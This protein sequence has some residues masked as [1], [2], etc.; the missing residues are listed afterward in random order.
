M[1]GNFG[2]GLLIGT[3]SASRALETAR[4][5]RDSQ[6]KE[7]EYQ[8]KKEYE[9]ALKETGTPAGLE[10]REGFKIT[11]QDGKAFHVPTAEA[12]DAYVSS[13][14]T[15]SDKVAPYQEVNVGSK[16]LGQHTGLEGQA[17]AGEQR[18][19]YNKGADARM[20]SV[21]AQY[22]KPLEAAAYQSLAAGKLKLKDL[23]RKDR[24]AD[25]KTNVAETYNTPEKRNARFSELY[26]SNTGAFGLGEHKDQTATFKN[27]PDGSTEASFFKAD[28]TSA[29]SK[30][31]SAAQVQKMSMK[32]MLFDMV[33]ADPTDTDSIFKLVG[34]GV[35]ED[36]LKGRL[37]FWKATDAHYQRADATAALSAANRAT[38]L[39][40]A[41]KTQQD[42]FTLA[43]ARH[44]LAVDTTGPD[45]PA[46]K[47]AGI[48]L[49]REQEVEKHMNKSA[50]L[51]K[52]GADP[53]KV[54]E[55][56]KQA[57]MVL[58]ILGRPTT[59]KK[60]NPVTGGYDTEIAGAMDKPLMEYTKKFA[61]K[62]EGEAIQT[63]GIQHGI[64]AVP[65]PSGEIRW[66][67]SR[68]PE[69][70]SYDTLA[71]LVKAE[72]LG[73]KSKSPKPKSTSKPGSSSKEA[74]PGTFGLITR[75]TA[76]ALKG[77]GSRLGG[78]SR[79][80]AEQRRAL[81]RGRGLQ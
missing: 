22:N 23:Q 14:Y 20:S 17:A 10:N 69:G 59:I 50:D 45:S 32:Q 4:N 55:E 70:K 39:G 78:E 9:A 40:M 73:P 77:V 3:E 49:R 43:Q 2:R 54:A 38:Y 65:H 61:G 75:D 67:S 16:T 51:M 63:Y 26:A 24:I 29:G 41:A 19:K 44:K 46:A 37:D 42:A 47:T 8:R 76:D 71:E 7:E 48:L 5:W 62:E 18:D 52:A 27:L 81:E 1:A 21:A 12:R 28:G 11:G 34:M 13:G 31:F 30:V 66:A 58:N 25:H 79:S 53:G 72:K 35:R 36:E 33:G 57:D 56:M 6:R 64:R 68:T 15:S 80:A 74:L 60:W